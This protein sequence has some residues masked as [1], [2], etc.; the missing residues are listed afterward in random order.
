MESLED[1]VWFTLGSIWGRFESFGDKFGILLGS[2][3]DHFRII[4][5]S[6]WHQSEMI[7][8]SI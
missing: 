7:L 4:L 2:G 6:V 5:R 8:G 3:S 1:H